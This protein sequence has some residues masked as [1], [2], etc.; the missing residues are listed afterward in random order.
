M[1]QALAP[2]LRY[3]GD[4][5]MSTLAQQWL[6]EGRQQG[7]QQGMQQGIQ[8][9]MQ[10]GMQQG[11]QQ[12]VMELLLERFQSPAVRF[13]GRIEAI[14]NLDTLRLLV[15]RA[16]TVDSLAEFEQALDILLPRV[17]PIERRQDGA[18]FHRQMVGQPDGVE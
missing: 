11:T 13:R 7:I 10:Q 3:E 8:Q 17:T 2:V 5:L 6:E 14:H 18:V 1:R 16:A 15:R 9:G 4:E 12:N